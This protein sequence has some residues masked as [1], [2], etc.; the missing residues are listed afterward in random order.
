RATLGS[1]RRTRP[2][3]TVI[4]ALSR[5]PVHFSAQ[6]TSF[7][8]P[9][10]N[11]EMTGLVYGTSLPSSPPCHPGL[12][13]G[14]GM[15]ATLGSYRRTCPTPPV[16]PAWSRVPVHFSAQSTSFIAPGIN[17]EMPG[18]VY[19]TSPP[20]S[21]PSHPLLVARPSMR[22]TLGS[23]RRTCPTPPR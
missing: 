22:A 21:P 5:D 12:V 13:P 23:Y 9:G 2:T 4:P 17:P 6:S 19:G 16:V 18:L 14:Q 3:P 1:Y 10:I 8:A 15:R 20:S 7:I 11:P